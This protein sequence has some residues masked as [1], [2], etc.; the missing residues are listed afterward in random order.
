MTNLPVSPDDCRLFSVNQKWHC[1]VP[2]T[3]V[4]S[5][6]LRTALPGDPFD[7]HQW[8]WYQTSIAGPDLAEVQYLVVLR[9]P[10][11]RWIS[12]VVEFWSRAYPDRTWSLQ[13]NHDWLFDQIEF[14]VHTLPQHKFLDVIDKTQTTWLWTPAAGIETNPWFADHNIVLAD[15]ADEDR[16]LGNSRPQIWFD[17]DE[18]LSEPREGAVASIPSATIQATVT[19][20]LAQSADRVARIREYYRAD[21]DLIES[22]EFYGN[23]KP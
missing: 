11:Q 4:S 21:Y 23:V 3:K 7:I 15:V 8:R 6:F 5:T 17:G 19:Q 13:D 1:Y 16:N 20:L 14:D 9:D 18:R 12:G 2:I 22:V 10:V